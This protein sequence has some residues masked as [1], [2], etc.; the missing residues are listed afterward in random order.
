MG[1]EEE[2]TSLEYGSVYQSGVWRRIPV[3]SMETYASLEYGEVYQKNTHRSDML[4]ERIHTGLM[5]DWKRD[6]STKEDRH[7]PRA[8][9]GRGSSI[10][11]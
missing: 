7:A 1:E 6:T 8:H 5:D 3:W 9:Y 2:D 10:L 11:V 4:M